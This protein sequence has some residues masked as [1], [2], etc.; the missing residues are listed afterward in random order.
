LSTASYQGHL[1]WGTM[2]VPY[3]AWALFMRLYAADIY[4]S[5]AYNNALLGTMRPVSIF[6]GQNFADGNP[7]IQLLYG[8]THLPSYKNGLT[9]D[10]AWELVPNNMELPAE[11]VDNPTAVLDIYLNNSYKNFSGCPIFGLAGFNNYNNNYTWTM[12][13]YNNRLFV[14]TLDINFSEANPEARAEL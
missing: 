8:M 11:I 14:G 5:L 9:P 6:R 4:S 2:H 10:A 1:F 3:L 12:A 7:D 13:V